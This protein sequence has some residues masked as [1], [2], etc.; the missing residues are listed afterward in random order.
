MIAMLA[1]YA[2]NKKANKIILWVE[3]FCL[4]IELKSGLK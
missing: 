4:I 3:I 2:V 1:I